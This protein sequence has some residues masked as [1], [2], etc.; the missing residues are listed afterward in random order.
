[1]RSFGDDAAAIADRQIAVSTDPL[2]SYPRTVSVSFVD[3][4]EPQAMLFA[5]RRQM[6]QRYYVGSYSATE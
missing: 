3:G 6:G 5:R 2:R 4:R 1:M